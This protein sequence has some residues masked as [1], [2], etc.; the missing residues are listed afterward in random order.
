MK[1]TVK[2]PFLLCVIPLWSL[3]GIYVLKF[4][5]KS[6]SDCYCEKCLSENEPWFKT[7]YNKSIPVFLTADYQLPEKD[8]KWWNVL[9]GKGG[10]YSTY[11]ELVEEVFKVIPHR[12]SVM[13]ERPGCCKTCAVV[14]NS[15]NLKGSRYG[16][17]INLHDVVM[18][19]NYAPTKGWEADVGSKTTHRIMYPESS[20]HLDNKTRLVMFPFKLEDLLWLPKTLTTGYFV[21]YKPKLRANKTLAMVVNPAFMKYVHET[22]LEKKG[23]Y[24][25]TGFLTLMMAVHICDEIHVFGF[26]ADKFGDWKHYWDIGRY[27]LKKTGGHHGVFEYEIIQKLTQHRIIQFFP[28]W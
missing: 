5:S 26:G 4:S 20:T 21:R 9:R 1:T 15:I 22:W 7:R 27:H 14:G 25:S 28:G 10:N 24:P 3:V 2:L 23:Y 11:I 6:Q 16:P 13:N 8:F 19:I 12:P 18:R 17:L